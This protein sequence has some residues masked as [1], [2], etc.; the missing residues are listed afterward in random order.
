MNSQYYTQY[1]QLYSQ[2]I[3]NSCGTGSPSL[4]QPAWPVL[5]KLPSHQQS[6]QQQAPGSTVSHDTVDTHNTK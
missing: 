2:S 5:A 6:Q 4:P 3:G 1:S